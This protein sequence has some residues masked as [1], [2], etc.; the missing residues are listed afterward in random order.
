MEETLETVLI[1]VAIGGL[2]VATVT[3]GIVAALSNRDGA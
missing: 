2:V 3:M 1:L